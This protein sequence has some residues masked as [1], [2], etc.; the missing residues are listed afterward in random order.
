MEDL[1]CL[2]NE[3]HRFSEAEIGQIAYQLLSQLDHLH[4]NELVYKYLT[5]QHIKIQHGYGSCSK[6]IGVQI[7]D[8]AVI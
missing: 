2:A 3:R 6:H 7:T 5:P 4:K 1:Y 8:I